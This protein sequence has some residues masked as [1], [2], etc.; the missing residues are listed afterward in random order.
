MQ[1]TLNSLIKKVDKKNYEKYSAY[2]PNFKE[3]KTQKFTTIVL[4]IIASIVLLIFA[5]NPT[6]STIANL[7]K[8]ID[9]SKFVKEKLDQKVN[10][11]SILQTQYETIQKDLPTV[12][13]AMPQGAEAPKFAGQLQAIISKNNLTIVSLGESEI[14]TTEIDKFSAFTFNITLTGELENMLVFVDNLV[15][16]DRIISLDDITISKKS[17]NQGEILQLSVKGSALFKP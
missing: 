4:T 10:N 11:L 3:Q 12:Y 1:L 2:V 13:S 6:L 7:H 16:I 9:D 5:I 15:K 14:Y 17:S 8:Q